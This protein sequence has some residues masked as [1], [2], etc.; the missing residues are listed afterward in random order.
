MPSTS[1]CTVAHTL[2]HGACRFNSHSHCCSMMEVLTKKYTTADQTNQREI[3]LRS[4]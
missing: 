4:H 1:G 2:P 3:S